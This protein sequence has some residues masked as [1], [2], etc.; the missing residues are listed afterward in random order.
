MILPK[1]RILMLTNSRYQFLRMSSAVVINVVLVKVFQ[2]Y[3]R[4]YPKVSGLT[5][6]SERCKWYSSLYRYFMSQSSE[7]C[8]H[9]PLHCFWTSVYCCEPIFRYRLSPETFGYTVVRYKVRRLGVSQRSP[10]VGFVWFIE[11]RPRL[12]V[13]PL[14][15]VR[16][17]HWVF[18]E[19]G[20]TY[21]NMI[22]IRWLP[23]N[24]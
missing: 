7:F 6:W 16:D 11:W 10:F 17:V 8:R 23:P 2:L 19:V 5:T 21:F 13:I 9:N 18:L 24:V 12:I 15:F 4:V 20:C 3:A 1:Y 14:V 22:Y